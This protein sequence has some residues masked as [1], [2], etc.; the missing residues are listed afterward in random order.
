[1]AASW[2]AVETCSIGKQFTDVFLQKT[3]HATPVE[4]DAAE[5][6]R[7]DQLL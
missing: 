3:K 4:K 7:T 2:G 5:V 1:M 6:R